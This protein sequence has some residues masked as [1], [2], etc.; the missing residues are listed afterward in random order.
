MIACIGENLI[1]MVPLP[2]AENA[3]YGAFKVAPGGCPY[4]SAIAAARLGSTVFYIGKISNDFLGDRLFNRLSDNGVRLDYIVRADN[5]VTLAFVEKSANGEARYAFY[6]ERAADRSLVTDDLPETL[7]P[8]IHFLLLGSISLLL[9]PGAGSILNFTDR[10]HKRVLISYDPNVRASMI[11]DRARFRA[12]FEAICARCAV[13]KA[14]DADLAWIYDSPFEPPFSSEIVSHI[15]ACGPNLVL[16]TRGSQGSLAAT[17]QASVS[18]GAVPAQ[19]VDTIGA[20]D[21][22]HAAALSF[23]D[24]NNW[25]STK[26]L[27]AL[28]TSQLE[29]MLRFASAAAAMDCM[30]EGAEPPTIEE[31]RLHFPDLALN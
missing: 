23:L 19:V 8:D 26:D 25:I 21:T 22:F 1:D 5:P 31:L 15:L 9:E 12:A 2:D 16:V 28:S 10:F 11:S 29:R 27:E 7:H 30:R 4:N 18:V 13:V 14:S 17:R 3:P 6:A 20:G 24:R